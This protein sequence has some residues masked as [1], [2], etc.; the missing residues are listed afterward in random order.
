MRILVC[1]GRNYDNVVRVHQA[2]QATPV[3]ATIIVGGARGADTLAEVSA[4]LLGRKV[5]TYYANWN[6]YGKSAGVRRNQKMLDTGID[7]VIA[8][9]GGNGTADMVRRAEKA[10]VQ[11]FYPDQGRLDVTDFREVDNV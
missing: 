3:D 1:G 8:F 7:Y 5:E 2:M 6:R 4:L 11:V 9:D 10:G